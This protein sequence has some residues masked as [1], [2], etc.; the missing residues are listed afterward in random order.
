LIYQA[1]YRASSV[2]LFLTCTA[3]GQCSLFTRIIVVCQRL[4]M[5]VCV[6]AVSQQLLV[7]ARVCTMS[8]QILVSRAT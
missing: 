6:K 4:F 3:R 1:H 5:Y 8:V 2:G 7:E